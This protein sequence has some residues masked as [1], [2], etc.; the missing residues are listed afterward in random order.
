MIFSS[1]LIDDSSLV[2]TG[3]QCEALAW[4]E[5]VASRLDDRPRC[6]PLVFAVSYLE[7]ELE[8]RP[9]TEPHTI[10]RRIVYPADETDE[11]IAYFVAHE[12]GH[13]LANEAWPHLD[14]PSEENAASRIGVA[15]LLPRAPYR[16]D[17]DAVGWQLQALR[18]LWPLASPW[19]LARR[20]AEVARDG[21]VASRWSRR[22]CLDRIASDG[23]HIGEGPSPIEARIARAA[24]LTGDEITA[25]PRDPEQRLHAWP[26]P[27]GGAIV[28]CGARELGEQLARTRPSDPPTHVAHKRGRAHR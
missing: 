20:I 28:I 4:R 11:A 17:L 7:R 8:P 16:R 19:I 5:S 2:V 23:L 27:D 26:T 22:S 25:E 15:L 24:I 6:D 21:A 14:A 12:C 9:W 10:D 18:E 3:E 1:G 13:I